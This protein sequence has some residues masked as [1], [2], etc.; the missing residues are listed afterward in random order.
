MV[1][2]SADYLNWRYLANPV[3]RHEV[4]TAREADRLVGYAIFT[5]GDH[6]MTLV[7]L[8]AERDTGAIAALI[9]GAVGL[10]W[11]RGL[12]AVSISL[13]QSSAWI[14]SVKQAGFRERDPH[15][16]VV[17]AS[18]EAWPEIGDAREWLLLDGDRDS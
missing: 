1:E 5:Q 8:F 4:L 10:A 11:R 14:P 12:D 15:P 7:D 2:R 17:H 6:V 3:H 9:G 18:P 16:V 13:W